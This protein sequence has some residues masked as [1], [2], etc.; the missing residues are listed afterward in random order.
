MTET[1]VIF[2]GAITYAVATRYLKLKQM[3]A[4]GLSLVAGYLLPS[5]ID[6]SSGGSSSSSSIIY[7]HNPKC[8]HCTKM[9][10]YLHKTGLKVKKVDITKLGSGY[11]DIKSKIKGVPAFYVGGNIKTGGEAFAH[12]KKITGI[13]Q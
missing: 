5:L 3:E 10:S 4:L 9:N 6:G 11:D 1:S 8:P 7:F 12:V 2:V 13:S